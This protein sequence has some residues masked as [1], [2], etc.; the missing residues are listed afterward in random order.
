MEI[1]Y[2]TRKGHSNL[3]EKIRELEIEMKDKIKEVSH[4]AS[5]GDIG[6]ENAEYDASNESLQF[7]KMRLRSLIHNLDEARI[8]EER[9]I[10]TDYV[11]FG[12]KIRI[13]QIEIQEEITYQ[14]VGPYETDL[15]ENGISYLAPLIRPFICKLVGDVVEIDLN[16]EKKTFEILSINKIDYK[17]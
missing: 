5:Y 7:I 13:K 4:V 12:T 9:D 16:N 6:H 15:Y 3:V 2:L 17:S 10:T 14:I 1:I 11:M 8:F